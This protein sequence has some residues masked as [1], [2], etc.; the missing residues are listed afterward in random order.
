MYGVMISEYQDGF[1]LGMWYRDNGMGPGCFE[2]SP[3]PP[4]HPPLIL[5]DKKPLI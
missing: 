5:T 4:E 3:L 2:K 1:H